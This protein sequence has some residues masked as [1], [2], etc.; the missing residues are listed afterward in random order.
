MIVH[1]NIVVVLLEAGVN[2]KVSA[3]TGSLKG[4]YNLAG[5]MTTANG[6]KVAFYIPL[7]L[8]LSLHKIAMLDAPIWFHFETN[9]IKI[10]ITI[11]STI[12]C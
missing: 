12:I 10:S 11:N 7:F 2:G 1:C 8:P 9:Y 4:V 5:F 6:Q 3:K